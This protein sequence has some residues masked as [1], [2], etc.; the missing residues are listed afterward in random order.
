MV[1]I[2]I[3]VRPGSARPGVGGEHDGALVVRVS[4]PAVDGKATAAALAAVAAAFG[5]RPHAVTL[6]AGA[7][8]RRKI[9]DLAGADRAAA[10]GRL[11]AFDGRRHG[12][13]RRGQRLLVY[14]PYGWSLARLGRGSA[15][16]SLY[17]CADV[18]GVGWMG[19][20][21][22][23]SVAVTVSRCAGTV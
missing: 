4:A 9:V 5:A 13:R 12:L 22:R 21:G 6:V 19:V 8:S 14:L 17:G 20:L 2:T 23:D 18:G 7:A 11:L 10:L 1:R 15:G 16:R 3:W